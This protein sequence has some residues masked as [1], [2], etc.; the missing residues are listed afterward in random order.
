MSFPNIPQITPTISINRAQ[1]TNL[2]L[3]SIALEELGLAHILNAEGEK[4]QAALGTL[5]GLSV[6]VPSFAG[7]ITINREVRKTLQTIIKK[8][9]LL[10]F[11][12]EDIL[13]IPPETPPTPPTPEF[14]EAGSAWSVGTDFGTGNAQYT[15]LGAE[16]TDKTVV[17]G[18]GANHTPI[19]TVH[20][21][22]Q[23]NN[24]EVTIAVVNPYVMDQVHLYV[25]NVAPVNS[26]PGLFP[27]QFTV[28]D[29]ALYFT[30]HTFVVDVSAFAGEMLFI[31]A[32]AHILQPV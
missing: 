29:P 10:Q 15:T 31:A 23:G 20:M 6:T 7:L 9:M 8:E 19:G 14:V 18:L 32:H 26:A 27:Y 28:N 12:L 30:S 16:E 4:L 13:D 21:V 24:L 1:V 3:A 17:L 5:R 11:K 25:S 22:R 2:L